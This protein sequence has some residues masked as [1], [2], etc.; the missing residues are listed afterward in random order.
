VE[1]AGTGAEL[2]NIK[3][4]Q[5]RRICLRAVRLQNCCST[6]SHLQGFFQAIANQ[7]LHRTSIRSLGGNGQDLPRVRIAT[8][9]LG[10]HRSELRLTTEGLRIGLTR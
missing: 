6:E 2:R 4:E 9:S 7:R 3:E 5:Q 1:A 8:K 10:S